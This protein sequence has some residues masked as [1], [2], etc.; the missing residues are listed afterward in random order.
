MGVN[1][2]YCGGGA[3]CG[4]GSE[5]TRSIISPLSALTRFL[6]AGI[7]REINEVLGVTERTEQ[8][9][10]GLKIQTEIS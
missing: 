3:G 8:S 6:L 9:G 7:S 4:F 1:V 5:E 10:K 2:M